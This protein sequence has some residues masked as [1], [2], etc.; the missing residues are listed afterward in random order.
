MARSRSPSDR[1]LI[2][3]PEFRRGD[4]DG[5]GLVDLTDPISNLDFLFLDNFQPTCMDAADSDD[6]GIVDVS[7]PIRNLTFQF[8]GGGEIPPP[9]PDCDI[10][11]TEDEGGDLGCESVECE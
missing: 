5:S 10:D 4:V 6:S 11:T 2:P 7:D 8:V 3:I 1:C 9:F